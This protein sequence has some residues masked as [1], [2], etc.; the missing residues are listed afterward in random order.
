MFRR[1]CVRSDSGF[2]AFGAKARMWTLFTVGA[3]VWIGPLL[4]ALVPR[5]FDFGR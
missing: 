2:W 1:N 4:V 3:V 5:L